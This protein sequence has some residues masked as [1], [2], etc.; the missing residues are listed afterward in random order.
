LKDADT[1]RL[2]AG[3]IDVLSFEGPQI[4]DITA[5]ISP[6]LFARFGLGPELPD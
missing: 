2:K 5:F 3:A 1:G 6:G 4:S